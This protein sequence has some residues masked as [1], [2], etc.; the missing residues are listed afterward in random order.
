[1][2]AAGS[3]PQRGLNQVDGAPS[4]PRTG[5]I[6]GQVVD[7]TG[8]PVPEAIVRMSMPKY[9]SDLPTTP[10]GRVMADQEG[11]FFFSDLPAGDY[12]LVATKDGYAGGVFGQRRPNGARQTRSG[13]LLD[14]DRITRAL[15]IPRQLRP[16]MLIE[17]A[18]V[19]HVDGWSP[20]PED[21]RGRAGPAVVNDTASARE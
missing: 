4:G 19:R 10:K 17:N 2:R 11:R 9:F 12:Y 15:H 1:V 7:S 8:A 16:V 6:V 5:L 20:R 18:A 13:Q 3:A 21:R 14:W